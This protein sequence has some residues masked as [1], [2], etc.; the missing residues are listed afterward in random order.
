MYL[1]WWFIA[2]ANGPIVLFLLV[3]IIY[4]PPVKKSL[5][6]TKTVYVLVDVV[7]INNIIYKLSQN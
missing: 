3:P 2:M 7:D 1:Q 5:T 4:E 6:L